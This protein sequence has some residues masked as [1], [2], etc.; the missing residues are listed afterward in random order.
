[1]PESENRDVNRNDRHEQQR[2]FQTC[3]ADFSLLAYHAVFPPLSPSDTV[4]PRRPIIQEIV[5]AK[6]AEFGT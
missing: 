4:P 1:M 5:N 3:S 2:Q 6:R